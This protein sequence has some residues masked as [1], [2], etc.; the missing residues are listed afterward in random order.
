L[1]LYKKSL[2][3]LPLIGIA[4]AASAQS[5]VTLFGVVDAT[6]A[7]G[8]GSIASR[9]QLLRGGLSSNRLGFRGSEDL[10]GGMAA[11]FWLEAG[12]NVDDGSGQATNIN[13]Q[14]SGG[15]L[16]GINGSQGLTFNR[17]STVSLSGPFGEARLGRD[18][19]PQYWNH[20]YGDPF[21]NIGVG[22]SINYTSIITGTTSTRA[23]NMISYFSPNS[24]GGLGVQVSHYFGENASNSPTSHD[25]DGNGV[26][27]NY[28]KGPLALAAGWGKTTYAAGDTVQRTLHAA[29]DFGVAKVVGTLNRDRAGT[30]NSHGGVIGVVASI[31][32][33]ELKASY[34]IH[35]TDAAGNPEAK[36]LAIGYVHNLSKRTALYTTLAQVRNSGGSALALNGAIT[37]PNSSSTGLDLGIRHSF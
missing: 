5:S 11:S 21:G 35:R 7:R 37:S 18:Y 33:N 12:M 36:K 4:G 13:N 1:I 9:T 25:G 20:V 10:G 8:T 17:R 15:A 16:A 29:Y 31:G 24:F 26:R 14:N 28:D 3:L 19:T 6:L 27:V 23:S 22:A 32:A 34:S 2:L 30:L